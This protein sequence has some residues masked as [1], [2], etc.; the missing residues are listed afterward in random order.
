MHKTHEGEFQLDRI[1]VRPVHV[2]EEERFQRLM[3]MHHYLGSLPKIGESVWYVAEGNEEWVAL[4]CF[5]AASLKC[6]ARDQW[7]GWS[8]RHQYDRLHLL[9]NNSR[10]LILPQWHHPNLASRVLSLCR[11]RLC[12][13]W[14]QR[15][16]HPLLLLETFV[17]PTRFAGTIYKADNWHIAGLTKGFRRTSVGY[18]SCDHTSKMVFVRPL[19]SNAQTLLSQPI[20]NEIYRHGKTNLMLTAKQMKTIPSIFQG[21]PDPRRGQ[22][23][24]HSLPTIMSLAVA[25]TL[26]GRSGYKEIH[27]YA[28]SLGQKALQHFRCRVENDKRVVPSLY[29]I[30]NLMVRVDPQ[31]LDNALQQWNA[32][33]VI[34]DESLAI[35]GKTMRNATNEE[36]RQTHIMSAIGHN[37]KNC[38]TQK[39]SAPYPLK[40]AIKPSKPTK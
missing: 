29:V 10:F 6:A 8:Y 33:Y 37:S 13:D 20:L 4:L 30:R 27:E 16:N 14:L 12:S 5:S 15:Y 26:C 38:Y 28:C 21:I 24:K 35:D 31:L 2:N 1:A 32:L 18:S 3:Q 34:D 39:K 11:K 22:G 25:A 40:A 7:I 23:R 36:G 9:A 17:D 19:Q